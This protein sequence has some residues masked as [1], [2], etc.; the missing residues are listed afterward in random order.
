MHLAACKGLWAQSISC[1]SAL[2]PQCCPVDCTSGS[3]KRTVGRLNTPAL[4]LDLP[5][6]PADLAEVVT[7]VGLA[8]TELDLVDSLGVRGWGWV[9]VGGPPVGNE[10]RGGEGAP[11][12]QPRCA[13]QHPCHD[14]SAVLS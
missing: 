13:I 11:D 6:R 1:Q 5:P 10:E 4:P 7:R 2:P 14:A 8:E 9:G 12:V 3:I